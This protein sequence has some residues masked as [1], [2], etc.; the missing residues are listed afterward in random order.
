MLIEKQVVGCALEF[1]FV[2][3]RI[4]I[5]SLWTRECWVTIDPYSKSTIRSFEEF[6]SSDQIGMCVADPP[7]LSHQR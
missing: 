4:T 3:R 5:C 6:L 2:V 7:A 1:S